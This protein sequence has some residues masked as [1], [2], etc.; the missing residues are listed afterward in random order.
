ML[1]IMLQMMMTDACPVGLGAVL[2]QVQ[3]CEPRV[4]CYASRNLSDCERRY[5]QTEKEALALVW[6]CGRF[7]MYVYGIDF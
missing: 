4:I 1:Q 2:I 3:N 5:S 7:H 6:A